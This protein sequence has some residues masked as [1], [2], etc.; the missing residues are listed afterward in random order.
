MDDIKQQTSSAARA[1]GEAVGHKAEE[2]AD[3]S[4]EA[5]AGLP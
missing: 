5:G 1:V 4:R 3:R 2:I